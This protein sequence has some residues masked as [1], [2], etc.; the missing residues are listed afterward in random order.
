MEPPT[1]RAP[2]T[3][4]AAAEGRHAG[5]LPVEYA[6]S[7]AL[8]RERSLPALLPDPRGS[9]SVTP[10]VYAMPAAQ[11]HAD[12]CPTPSLS[13]SIIKLICLDSPAHAWTAHPKLN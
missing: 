5:I 11:Y 6:E 8:V 2:R 4:H 12:P 1:T 7:S 3:P 13:A 9:M 10:G